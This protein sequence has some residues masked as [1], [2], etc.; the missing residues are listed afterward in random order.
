MGKVNPDEGHDDQQPET[1]HSKKRFHDHSIRQRGNRRRIIF[2]LMPGPFYFA[3]ADEGEAFD[4][5]VHNREDEAVTALT[6]S[7]SEGDFAS[8]Q[9]DVLNP[10]EGLLAPGRQQWCWLSWD[11]GSA[12]VP[13]FGGRLV[14]VPESIEGEAVRLLFAARPLDYDGAKA[15][16]AETLRVLPYYDPV[17]IAGDLGDDDAV[18]TG[19]GA[20]W[21]IDR[22][23]LDLSISDELVGEAGTLTFGEADH[24]YDDFSLSYAEPPLSS[25]NIEGT[26][27]WTQGGTGTID[28]TW[29]I[30]SAFDSQKSLYAPQVPRPQSGV[31]SSLTGDGLKSDWPK[32]AADISGG[33][34][35]GAGT[36]IEEANKS[37]RRYNY[38]VEYRQMTPPPEATTPPLT[39]SISSEDSALLQRYGTAF[40]YFDSYSDYEVFFPI[41]ALKQRTY[42]DWTADRK[43]TEIVR[44]T[45]PADIQ[46]LLVEPDLEENVG[47]ISLNASDTVTEPDSDG[48]MPGG[49]IRRPGYLNTDRGALSMQ[50]VLL[51]GRTELR[52][53]ARCVEVSCR[54]PWALGIA[55]TL[56]HNAHIVDYRCPGGEAIG[57]IVSYSFAASGNGEFSAS[58]TV[59]CAIGHGGTVSAAAG[60]LTYVDA[61]YVAAGYQQATGAELTLPTGDLVYQTLD[62]FPLDDDGIN[63]QTLDA[64]TAVEYITLTGG[65]HDQTTVVSSVSDPI[66]ALN[67][68][69][70]RVCV[71]FRQVAGQTFETIYTPLVVPLPIPQLIDLEAAA[72]G[73]MAA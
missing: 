27:A 45:M 20:R 4:P 67:Q 22:V 50:Y 23:T 53:R 51:L 33:W 13:L 62:D 60:T 11:N 14:A 34:K 12:I 6:V 48:L 18:L 7:Q 40:T 35:V 49:D 21:H 63:L 31:I 5:G 24:I 58:I 1:E 28:M 17:W 71:K 54:V 29:R 72:P 15:A 69:P 19:Y 57:K 65:L 39:S 43:R 3:W 44:C 25:V 42:F 73:R 26:L 8:L 38:H 2:G 46:P 52:R 66:D 70:S 47:T 16:L 9:I 37:Y 10:G 59:G 32:P 36:Y 64:I 56:R 41:S 68:Y 30:Q 55:A 61:G